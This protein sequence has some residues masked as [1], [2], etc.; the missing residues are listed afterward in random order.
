MKSRKVWRSKTLVNRKGTTLVETVVTMSIMIP[1][2]I[3]TVLVIAEV[4]HFYAIKQGLLHASRQAARSMV[5]MYDES[6]LIVNNRPS[7]NTLVYDQV[8]VPNVVSDT[9][10]FDEAKFN[11]KSIPPIVTVTAHYK[12]GQTGLPPF[13]WFDPLNMGTVPIGASATYTL[14]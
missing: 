13:P 3:A 10:Q 11:T 1:I 7:Q 5:A 2:M 4:S 6:P 12:G 9:T 8:R 14:Y